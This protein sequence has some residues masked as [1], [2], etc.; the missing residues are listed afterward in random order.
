[1][2]VLLTRTP[3]FDDI[4]DHPS[5]GELEALFARSRAVRAFVPY[6]ARRLRAL[7]GS[8]TLEHYAAMW[9]STHGTTH[10]DF[11]SDIRE[12]ARLLTPLYAEFGASDA[13]RLRGALVEGLVRARLRSRY[14][15]QELSDNVTLELENGVK[16]K[17]ST[18][19]DVVGWDN[20]LGECHDCKVHAK[21]FDVDL[22]RE[23]D[24]NLPRKHFKI[25]AVTTESRS[26]ALLALRRLGCS[27]PPAN[28]TV[29]G[30]ENLMEFAPLQA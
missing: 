22:L 27:P 7:P 15:P 3:T 29:I 6:V 25:G 20:S 13:R 26:A 8:M 28:V 12:A 16:Y 30:L 4:F 18:S 24:R 11:C 5:F 19:V 17:S 14:G 2:K 1:M 9:A 10:A 23:L 21:R